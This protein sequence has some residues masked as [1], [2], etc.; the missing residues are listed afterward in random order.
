MSE[1]RFKKLIVLAA[2]LGCAVCAAAA[3]VPELT[4]LIFKLPCG[5]FVDL[6]WE[7]AMTGDGWRIFAIALYVLVCLIPAAALLL[8]SVAVYRPFCRYLCPLGAVYGL[9]NPIALHRFAVEEHKCVRCGKC[10]SACKLDIAAYK[11][12]NSR[13]C[14][15]CGECLRA[16]PT[17]AL[18]TLLRQRKAESGAAQK[19]GT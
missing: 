14:I 6:L 15:R 10:Q 7:L 4:I 2:V 9:F 17:G 11:T 3:A 8:L 16:C 12:P 18:H 19:S 5:F 13:E 1:T